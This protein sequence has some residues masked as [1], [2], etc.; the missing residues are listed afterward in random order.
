MPWTVEVFL[1]VIII[2]A[3]CVA[4]ITLIWGWI[5][6]SSKSK[7][8]NVGSIFSLVGFLFATSSA[9]A[10]ISSLFYAHLIHG[11]EFYDPRL[12]HFMRWGVLLSLCGFLFGIAGMWRSNSL[13][14]QAPLCALGT[15]AF[16]MAVAAAQ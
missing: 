5:K 2:F 14:W 6:W 12:L 1:A 13:R 16:W 9:I 8:W 11:F 3:W 15:L 10:A 7:T 4:P